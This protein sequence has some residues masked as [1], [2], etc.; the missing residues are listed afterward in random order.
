MGQS[1]QKRESKAVDAIK[2]A[3]PSSLKSNILSQ[4]KGMFAELFENN[5]VFP[6]HYIASAID[7]VGTKVI[8]AEAMERY[9]TIGIDCVAVSANDLATLGAVNPFLFMDCIFCQSQ[10][11]EKQITGDIVKGMSS[12]LEQCNASNILKNSIRI[13]FGKGETASVDELLSSPKQGHGFE[14]VGAMIGFIEK[15][16][17]QKQKI[18][19]GQK[20]IAL[21]SSGPHSNGY[22]DLRHYLLKGDFETRAEIKKLYKG[23]FSLD[24][25]FE[26]STIGKTLLE[27]TKIYIETMAKISKNFDV[28]GINNTGYGLKN[29]NRIKEKVEFRI[30]NPLKPQAIFEL[31][32]KE[33]RFSDE[34]M[35]KTFNMGMGFFVIYDKENADDILDIAKDADIVGEIRKSNK[36]ITVLEKNNKKIVFEGY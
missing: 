21:G 5:E 22:T 6:K 26:N 19:P 17:F 31:M 32:Q 29:F 4:S 14:I 33:S 18:K 15:S 2:R 7:S 12:G 16:K 36:T 23:R 27:P 8:L 28:V 1:Y 30:N 13:N 10:V 25:K 34:Q 9:E 3:I 20:I 35:Y 11:Q 24:D